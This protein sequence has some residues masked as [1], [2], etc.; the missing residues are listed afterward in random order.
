VKF[1]CDIDYDPFLVMEDQ[2]K[3]YGT[4]SWFILASP[5]Y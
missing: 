4:L 3:V 1:F 5:V 2:N